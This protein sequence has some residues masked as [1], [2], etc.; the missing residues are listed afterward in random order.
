MQDEAEIVSSAEHLIIDRIS[1][2][3]TQTNLT[4]RVQVVRERRM[5]PCRR[6]I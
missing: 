3:V 4:V 1:S 2:L 6:M 5:N